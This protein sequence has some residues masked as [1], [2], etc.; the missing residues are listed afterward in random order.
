LCG[1]LLKEMCGSGKTTSFALQGIKGHP[2][3]EG[4][5]T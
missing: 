5:I 2:G 3:E 4:R 1:E